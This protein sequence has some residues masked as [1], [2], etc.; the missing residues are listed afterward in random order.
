MPRR[1]LWVLAPILF[2]ATEDPRIAGIQQQLPDGG[3]RWIVGTLQEADELFEMAVASYGLSDEMQEILSAELERRLIEQWHHQREAVGN[4]LDASARMEKA[5]AGIGS[6]EDAG[7]TEA[8]I[9]LSEGGPL[10]PARVADWLDA[11][12]GL[13]ARASAR[14]RLLE[15]VWRRTAVLI[16][17]QGD[18]VRR[19]GLKARILRARSSRRTECPGRPEARSLG[20]PSLAQGSPNAESRRAIVHPWRGVLRRNVPIAPWPAGR[21]RYG[22]EASTGQSRSAWL[23]GP[24]L[25]DWPMRME[26][27][28]DSIEADPQGGVAHGELLPGLQTRVAALAE[29]HPGAVDRLSACTSRRR[30]RELL[31]EEG[32]HEGVEALFDEFKLRLEATLQ[33]EQPDPAASAG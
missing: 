27:R 6:P 1:F 3:Q 12:F 25:E 21:G 26:R 28:A 19:S 11:E 33:R 30:Y 13:A 5:G 22:P 29:S 15:L 16:G 2:T 20:T 23:Y 9:E 7:V 31:R 32:L 10:N 18:L 24:V 4:A 8:L 14:Q 17:E